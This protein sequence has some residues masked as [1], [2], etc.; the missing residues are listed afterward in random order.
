M[1]LLYFFILFFILT[2]LSFFAGKHSKSVSLVSLGILTV[3][4]I[5]Y[6]IFDFRNYTGGV[7]SYYNVLLTSFSTSGI[8]INI[9]F[10]LGLTGFSDLLVII[11]LLITMFSILM[12]SKSHGAYF[13]GLFMAAGFG[14][15]GLFMV[16]NFLFFYIF[17]E[18][19]LIPVFFII[20]KY[21]TGNKERSSL[22]FFIYTH[23]GSLFLLLSI[24]TLSTY[25]FLKTSIFT[26]QIGDLMNVAFIIGIPTYAFYFIIFG[27]LLAFLIKLPTF[28]LHAWLPD[29]YYDAP[30]SGT[31]MLSGG[32]VAMGG[33]GLLGIL[34][35]IAGLFPK[36]LVYFIILLGLISIIYFAFSALFQADLKRMA[37]YGSAAEMSFI[38]IAFGTALLSTGYVRTLDLS[39]GMYQIIAHT[40]VAALIF[41]SLSL[42]YKRTGTSRIYELGGLNRELPILSSFLLVGMLASLGLPSLAGFIGEFSVTISAFQSIGLYTLFIVVGLIVIAAFLIWAAQRTLFGYFNERLG[43]L[44]DVNKQEFLILF[45]IMVCTIFLGV[46]PTLFFKILTAYASHLGGLI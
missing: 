4:F 38:T 46:Y 22:K 33:Y 12:G 20:G 19:V 1:I 14:L 5:I 39:G 30:Y 18:V 42:L 27:F 15:A 21:G 13:Y 44:R 16:R 29:A 41:A 36:Y 45:F 17:W 23:I 3:F 35:P 10:S 8:T 7:I 26:F 28:P 31:I 37:A 43:R 32:L 40:F 2:G 9:N 34:Y 24:F 6:S 11:A 25:Y